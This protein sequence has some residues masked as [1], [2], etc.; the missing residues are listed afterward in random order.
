M[1]PETE[2]LTHPHPIWREQSNFLIHGL[3]EG[4]DRPVYEQ[5]WARQLGPHQFELCC[6]PVLLY[7]TALG[8]VV[9]TDAAYCITRVAR[10]SGRW[11][12]RAWSPEVPWHERTD[13]L[14]E[15]EALGALWELTSPRLLAVDAGSS[16][17]ADRV[18]GYL[19]L[20]HEYG[21]LEV[22]SGKH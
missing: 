20:K 7:N 3:A 2:I 4:M 10:P 9:E 1:G 21:E 12:F 11:V 19:K 15:L 5:L 18:L 14:N 8:D 16:E 17:I 13:D 22:E 6:I